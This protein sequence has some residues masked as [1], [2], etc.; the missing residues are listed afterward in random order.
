MAL[1]LRVYSPWSSPGQ[2]LGV[3]S[4]SLLQGI[5]PTQGSNSGL[6]HCRRILYQLSHRE[7]QEYRSGEPI[8]SPADL[9]GPGVEPGSP[10]LQTDSLPIEPPGKASSLSVTDKRQRNIIFAWA[11]RTVSLTHDRKGKKKCFCSKFIFLEGAKSHSS[12][13]L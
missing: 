11:T 2:N 6:P 10:A 4:L 8:P 9:P 5:F 7:A 13:N 1:K 3:G 12:L